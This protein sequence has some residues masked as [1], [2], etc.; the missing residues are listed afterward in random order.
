MGAEGPLF[1][2]IVGVNKVGLGLGLVYSIAGVELM[3]T[4][5]LLGKKGLTNQLSD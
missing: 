3:I 4:V 1:S 5:P 2:A